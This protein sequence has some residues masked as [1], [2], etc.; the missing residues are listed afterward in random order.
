MKFNKSSIMIYA[1]ACLAAPYE[2]QAQAISDFAS[3]SLKIN[4]GDANLVDT[5]SSM[6][7]GWLSI[8]SSG[9]ITGTILRRNFNNGQTSSTPPSQLVVANGS[10]VFGPVSFDGRVTNRSGDQY[11][12]NVTVRTFYSADFYI[13]TSNPSFFVKG[14][15]E[16][17]VGISTNIS[18]YTDYIQDPQNP[19]IYIP[20]IKFTTNTS[21]WSC[22]NLGGVSFGAVG[23]PNSPAIRGVFGASEI[24]D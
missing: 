6:F 7:G 24:K 13:A 21:N 1:A 10:R 18:S 16:R 2:S 19:D 5:R 17:E 14:R 9:A 20:A 23:V 3:P 4:G 15:A 11:W 22:N 8:A 12:T